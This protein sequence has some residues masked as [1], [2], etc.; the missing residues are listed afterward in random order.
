MYFLFWYLRVDIFVLYFDLDARFDLKVYSKANTH[1][2]LTLKK[3][4][5]G[6]IFEALLNV[7]V[8][9]CNWDKQY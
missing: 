4:H 1:L 6:A 8:F 2:Y 9:M 3:L 5:S 7:L